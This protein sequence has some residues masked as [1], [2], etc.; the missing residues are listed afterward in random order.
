[1][2]YEY[3]DEGKVIIVNNLRFEDGTID[4][5]WNKGRPCLVL[6]SD[7]EYEYILPIKSEIKNEHYFDK[8]PFD[9]DSFLYFNEKGY[10]ETTLNDFI[11]TSKH[12]R[13]KTKIKKELSGYI[14]LG[15][16]LKIPIAYR[17]E[18]G[19]FKYDFFKKIID[20]L[21]K[22]QKTKNNEELKE[23]AFNGR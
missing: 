4:H 1:M 2:K 22:I 8:I 12:C 16:V 3:L 13:I 23:K 5:A 11:G 14:N 17:N 15:H 9:K 20:R 18:I 21:H 6:F 10:N 7:D 19:K